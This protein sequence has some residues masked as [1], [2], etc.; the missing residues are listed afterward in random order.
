[1]KIYWLPTAATIAKASIPEGAL[2]WQIGFPTREF[3]M[4]WSTVNNVPASIDTMLLLTDG[5]VLAHVL[6][7]PKW[8]RLIPDKNGSYANGNWVETASMLNDSNLT[9]TM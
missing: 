4:G 8:Y 2:G 7:S 6:A 9:A 1:M 5:S 3:D